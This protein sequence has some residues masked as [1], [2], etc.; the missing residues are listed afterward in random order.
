MSLTLRVKAAELARFEESAVALVSAWESDQLA[1]LFVRTALAEGRVYG[2]PH[3]LAALRQAMEH[4]NRT[5]EIRVV[6][7]ADF[8]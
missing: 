1:L 8:D 3:E 4:G 2:E 6:V 5:P 7:V